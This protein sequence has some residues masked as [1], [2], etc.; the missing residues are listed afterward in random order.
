[1]HC[2]SVGVQGW[3]GYPALW[4]KVEAACGDHPQVMVAD[5]GYH[6]RSVF[7]YNIR[8]R[9]STVAPWGRPGAGGERE[10]LECERF[11]RD[12]VA[13]CRHCG[14]STHMNGPGLGLYSDERDEPRLRVEC[15][16][17]HTPACAGPQSVAC[18][19]EYR[20]LQPVNR[21]QR[22]FYDLLH[23]HKNKESLFHHW[24][25]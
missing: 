13:R 17:Q 5:K 25:R 2:T 10:D 3:D 23:S 16:L 21:T 24:R 11:D 6:V 18:A 9:V 8:R 4:E 14:S 7:E 22:L 20:L 12:G 15:A 1:M 19:E